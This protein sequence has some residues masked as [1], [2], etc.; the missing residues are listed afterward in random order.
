MQISKT[1][2]LHSDVA[3]ISELILAVPSIGRWIGPRWHIWP[4]ASLW[5]HLASPSHMWNPA[6]LWHASHLWCTSHLWNPAHMRNP[7]HLRSPAY[8]WSSAHLW[9]PAHMWSPAHVWCPAHRANLSRLSWA[10]HALLLLIAG[11]AGLWAAAVLR[12]RPGSWGTPH[13]AGRCGG[14]LGLLLWRLLRQLLL[15]GE[16]GVGH[17]VGRAVLTSGLAEWRWTCATHKW[18]TTS[19]FHPTLFAVHETIS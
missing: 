2:Y 6:H 14:G 13:V 4:H 15:A 1:H 18:R 19:T 17:L 10:H 9:S 3:R 7:T 16:L 12:L 8:L 11:E 5:P